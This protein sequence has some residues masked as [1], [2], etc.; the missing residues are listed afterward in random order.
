MCSGWTAQWLRNALSDETVSIVPQVIKENLIR[1][2]LRERTSKRRLC[3]TLNEFSL[4]CLQLNS[5]GL[6][7]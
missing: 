7:M 6:Q 3:E 1:N 4:Q 5:A 2:I